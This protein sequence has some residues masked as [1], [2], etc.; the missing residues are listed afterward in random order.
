MVGGVLGWELR[1]RRPAAASNRGWR[2]AGS[3]P[4]VGV[5]EGNAVAGPGRHATLGVHGGAQLV[6]TT[7]TIEV[8]RQIILARP[9]QLYRYA[10]GL[11]GNGGR[12]AGV[13]M[14]QASAETPAGA[15]LV[16][17]SARG[18]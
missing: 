16:Q 17:R 10:T 4:G 2:T 9:H 11:L 3:H 7:S 1:R 15:Q 8:V 6:E 18:R 13:V 14:R 5:T 12:L